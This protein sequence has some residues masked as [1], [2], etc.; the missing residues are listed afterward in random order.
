MDCPLSRRSFLHAMGAAVVGAHLR[1][2]TLMEAGAGGV[3]RLAHCELATAA[4]L[5]AMEAFYHGR[6]ALRTERSAGRLTVSAGD[7]RI[8]FVEDRRAANPFY[9][10]AF[11]IPENKIVAAREWQLQRSPLIPIPD[12]NRARDLPSDIVDYS[13]WNAHSIFFLDP[14]GNVVEY[15]ARHD[16]K[17]AAAGPFTSRDILGV[18]EIALIVDDVPG[19]VAKLRPAL[20]LQQYRGSSDDF[21][22]LGD[23]EGLVLVMRR[24][25]ILNFNQA[26]EEKAAKVYPTVVHVRGS[27]T[28]R[29][30]LDGFP[31]ELHKE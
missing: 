4:T 10:F 7:T 13:H 3:H 28:D 12:R 1:G 15:I 6:L 14:G 21:A 5:D 23:E 24:G 27:S 9:H 8:T 18:T 31:Y 26:S 11:N 2:D 29:F 17:N 16:L 30:Q 22:A 25:R 19:T 20:A